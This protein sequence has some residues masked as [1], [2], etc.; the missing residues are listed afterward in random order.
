MSASLITY[1]LKA[2]IRDKLIIAM[3][4]LIALT[5]SMSI[6]MA[7][8]AITEQDQ[9]LA[10]YSSGSLRILGVLGLVIFTAFF[11]RRSFDSKD[12][13]FLLSRPISRVSFIL[14]HA[15][16]FSILAILVSF[17]STV[18]LLITTSS[19]AGDALLLWSVSI[20]VEAIIM[21]NMAFFF[22]M[23]LSS[24][25]TAVLAVL[26]FYVLSR[27]MGQI[28]GILESGTAGSVM[29]GVQ[30]AMNMVSSLTP[31]LDLMGQ[32]TWLVYG[33]E[34]SPIGFSFILMQG[35]VFLFVVLVAALIDLVLRQF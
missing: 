25:A 6:F 29:E 30:I 23:F 2:A 22:A 19:L 32:T 1:V 9:F 33:I 13:E 7:S 10:V 11:V 14:S 17:A 31:R 16:A 20:M 28:L 34:S 5:A 18:A 24:A 26:A 8:S 3:L 27:M 15:V 12:V 4:V 35:S 21:V